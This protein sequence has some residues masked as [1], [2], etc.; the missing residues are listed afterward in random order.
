[1]SL[2]WAGLRLERLNLVINAISHFEIDQQE[3]KGT[4]GNQLVQAKAKTGS[5]RLWRA[6]SRLLLAQLLQHHRSE[7]GDVAGAERKQHIARFGQR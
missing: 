6:N 2:A 3:S 7:L 4:K 1:M 5:S